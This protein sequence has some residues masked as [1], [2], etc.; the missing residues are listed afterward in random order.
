MHAYC[1][2][3][4]RLSEDAAY[5]RIQAARAGRQFPALF[6]AVSEG[7]LHLAA[8]C[9]L[10]PHLTSENVDELIERATHR[11][12]SEVETLVAERFTPGA[13]P[14]PRNFVRALP[15]TSS[16]PNPQ[17][18][19]GQVGS[20]GDLLDPGP[21]GGEAPAASPQGS[22]EEVA[23]R[24]AEEPREVP[25][26]E[27]RFLVRLTIDKVTHDKL[28][29]AQALLRHAV[30]SGDVAE[31]FGRAL[32]TLIVQLERRKTGATTRPQRPRT[33]SSHNP[34]YISAPVRRAVWARDGGQCTFVSEAGRRCK[35]RRLLEYDH[36][37]PVARG[38]E[39]TVARLR[40]RCRAH[41]QYEAER[42]FGA[43][44]MRRKRG[45]G[46]TMVAE[47]KPVRARWLPDSGI[48]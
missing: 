36:V 48:P 3:E 15:S 29:H 47:T 38:G 31:V 9:L 12:K 34:R 6:V 11:R 7:R 20:C 2:G 35:A 18:A 32:D 45:E 19:P 33:R 44:F 28:R 1:V 21:K 46:R 4:L 42:V 30:P 24:Q 23:R 41:N 25:A 39:A 27:E 37:D 13:V 16:R 22:S 5:K 10:A 40:L 26:P 43:A 14:T 17:L 8:A